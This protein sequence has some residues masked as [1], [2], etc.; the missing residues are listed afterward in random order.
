MQFYSV[1]CQMKEF[2]WLLQYVK[3]FHGFAKIFL[4]YIR[5]ILHNYNKKFCS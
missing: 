2:S 1:K 3:S 5:L 4:T